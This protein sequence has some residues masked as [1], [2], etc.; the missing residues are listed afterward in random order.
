M[1]KEAPQHRMV[2]AENQGRKKGYFSKKHPSFL[3]KL[4][5]SA[6]DSEH[7]SQRRF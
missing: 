4:E 2:N 6:H 7:K 1:L 3:R 5:S